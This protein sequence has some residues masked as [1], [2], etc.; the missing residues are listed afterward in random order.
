[1]YFVSE[2]SD[3]Y[4][5]FEANRKYFKIGGEQMTIFVQDMNGVDF[6]TLEQ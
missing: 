6:S 5:W 1:M 4:T 2:D 3:I